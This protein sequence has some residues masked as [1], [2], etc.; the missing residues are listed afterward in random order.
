M[1]KCRLFS[2]DAEF[3]WP[4]LSLLALCGYFST[5][6]STGRWENAYVFS[7]SLSRRESISNAYLQHL[8]VLR[9]FEMI[10]VSQRNTWWFSTSRRWCW[11]DWEV[12]VLLDMPTCLISSMV[13]SRVETANQWFDRH[14]M[15]MPMIG[16]LFTQWIWVVWTSGPKM[17]RRKLCKFLC[18]VGC[19]E[20]VK[21]HWRDS[22]WV[23]NPAG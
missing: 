12:F 8:Y 10:T 23:P 18:I 17:S 22:V 15:E 11:V 19:A 4:V 3:V 14:M 9:A 20:S 7:T 1:I 5:W 2:R 16:H 13:Y 6:T 21:L